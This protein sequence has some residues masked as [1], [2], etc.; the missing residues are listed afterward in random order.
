MTIGS[1]VLR[2]FLSFFFFFFFPSISFPFVRV[3]ARVF[4]GL[5]VT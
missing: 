4:T 1:H 2:L 3:I 5:G